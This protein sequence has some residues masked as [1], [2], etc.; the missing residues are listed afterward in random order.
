MKSF[1]QSCPS[2]INPASRVPRLSGGGVGARHR[3]VDCVFA[4]SP[5]C[6]TRAGLV[7][8][9]CILCKLENHTH[10]GGAEHN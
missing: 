6:R 9:E 2:V 5:A 3:D 7:E 8:K 4:Y 1:G 10:Q